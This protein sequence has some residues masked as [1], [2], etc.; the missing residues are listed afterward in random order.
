M[1]S[2]IESVGLFA[3]AIGC[4][5]APQSI[6]LP[7]EVEDGTFVEQQN[8]VNCTSGAQVVAYIIYNAGHTWP[9]NPGQLPLAG[10]Q[11]RNLDATRVVVNF[12]FP[13]DAP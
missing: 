9:P 11:S 8:F 1:V 7:V 6:P 10:A 4:D 13:V 12:F 3:A 5:P 2:Q